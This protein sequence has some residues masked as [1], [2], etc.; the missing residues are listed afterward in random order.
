MILNFR[1]I[2]YT[3]IAHIF[4]QSFT[5]LVFAQGE[6]LEVIP[7]PGHTKDSVSLKVLTP[8][9]FYSFTGKLLL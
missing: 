3:R 2:H 4:L 5:K 8:G 7:T 9:D 1:L 6:S